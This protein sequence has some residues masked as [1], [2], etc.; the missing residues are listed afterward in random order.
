[1]VPK[2]VYGPAENSSGPRCG[3]SV[4]RAHHR[5]WQDLSNRRLVRDQSMVFLPNRRFRS[6][7]VLDL[8]YKNITE[9]VRGFQCCISGRPA[10]Q[11]GPEH[12]R[13]QKTWDIL[14]CMHMV[15]DTYLQ[16]FWTVSF[17]SDRAGGRHSSFHS[18]RAGWIS[19]IHASSQ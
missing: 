15:R 14:H 2:L 10:G 17:D 12:Q 8:D 18:H 4:S 11:P 9:Q 7:Y 3:Q 5:P 13:S 19:H 6:R 16:L 1:M